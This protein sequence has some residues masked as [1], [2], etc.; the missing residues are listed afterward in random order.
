MQN[1]LAK[2]HA[3]LPDVHAPKRSLNITP[4]VIGLLKSNYSRNL[5]IFIDFTVFNEVFGLH[6]LV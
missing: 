4:V 1:V 6:W 3:I 2:H 5:D